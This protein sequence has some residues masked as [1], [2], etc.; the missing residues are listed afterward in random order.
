[1][2]KQQISARQIIRYDENWKEVREDNA[3]KK[4]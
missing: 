2:G 4:Q 3:D 1:M